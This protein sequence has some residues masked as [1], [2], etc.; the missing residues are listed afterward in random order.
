MLL[1]S[2]DIIAQCV[3]IEAKILKYL[4]HKEKSSDQLAQYIQVFTDPGF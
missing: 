1:V 3:S 2:L 4:S